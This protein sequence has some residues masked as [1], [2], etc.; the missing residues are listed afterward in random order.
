MLLHHTFEQT[1]ARYPSK[2]AL[3][4][5]QKAY[6]YGALL[7][8]TQR[9]A[10]TL[11][12]RGVARGDRVAVFLDNGVEAVVSFYACLKI[13]AVA[14]PINPL[15]K[16]QKLAYIF[17]DATPTG[18]IADTHLRP[19]YLP[20]LAET[21]SLRA[22]VLCGD[23]APKDGADRDPRVV[24][25]REALAKPARDTGDGATIDQDLAAII[26]T[27]GSTGE[28]KGVM[29]SH[30]NMVSAQSSVSEYLG[31]TADDVIMCAL[32]LAFDYGLYQVLMAFKVGARILIERTFAFPAKILAVMEAEQATVF[33]GVPTMF[34]TLLAMDSLARYDLRSLRLVTNT[35]A[36][37]SET[38]I[39][40]IRAAFPQ[41]ELF[42]MYGLTECKRVTFLPPA[43]LARRPTS[44]GRGM[45]NEE[46]YLVDE[47]GKRLPPGS[48]GELVIRGS[49]VMRGYWNKPKETAERLKPGELAGE[50]VLHSG[51]IFH[52]DYDGFL[53]FVGRSDDIIKSRGEKVSPKEV[54]NV[55]YALA[56]VREAA[57]IGV[58]DE[59]LGQAVKAY[60]VLQPGCHYTE[61]DVIK[62]CAASLE[63]FMAPK[64]VEFVAE[65]PKTD[66]GKIRKAGLNADTQANATRARL[67]AGPDQ[68]DATVARQATEATAATVIG[69]VTS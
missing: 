56:G 6:T 1:A 34:N 5:R 3:I 2:I 62:H 68:P 43:E 53:Y 60:V 42:S 46:V 58:A 39:Q 17:R 47:S 69:A 23:Y 26:Y 20:V 29:L 9:L 44:V 48:T 25:M 11:R 50:M 12:A 67:N 33:P 55:L 54:E 63:N 18:F 30:L 15:T 13:G 10:Q 64:Y 38:H 32:P 24:S 22:C 21:D 28:P 40:K 14:M 19:A 27:S 4:A 31:L 49:H 61:R 7:D 59:L 41:A 36:A 52:M 45:P 8:M 37:L 16:Y 66:T 51:D 65:L 57:V 35:A